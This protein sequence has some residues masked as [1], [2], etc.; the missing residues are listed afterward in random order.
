MIIRNSYIYRALLLYGNDGFNF[1]ILEYCDK[2]SVIYREHYYINLLNLEYN[3]LKLAGSS[4]KHK[5][6]PETLLNLRNHKFIEEALA[7]IRKGRAPI[8]LE[9]LLNNDVISR[10][11]LGVTMLNHSNNYIFKYK[12]IRNAARSLG[13]SHATLIDC[14]KNNRLYKYLYKITKYN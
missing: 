8:T 2:K 7:N 4:L 13:V 9:R 10:A 14:I 1:N 5:H 3:I 12:S 11:G 6:S